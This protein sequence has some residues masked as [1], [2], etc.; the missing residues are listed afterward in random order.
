MNIFQ[1]IIHIRSLNF[2]GANNGEQDSEYV[3]VQNVRTTY[4][5]THL[6]ILSLN[7]RKEKTKY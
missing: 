7:D 5:R 3:M 2:I 6:G 1:K 4:R